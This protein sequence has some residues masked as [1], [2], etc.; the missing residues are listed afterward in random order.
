M[1][2]VFVA[3]A[4]FGFALSPLMVPQA[5]AATASAKHHRLVKHQKHHAKK[6]VVHHRAHKRKATV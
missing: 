6:K 5:Q 4:I 2:K 3:L 1:K